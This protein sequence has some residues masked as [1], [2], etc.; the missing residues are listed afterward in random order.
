MEEAVN[1]KCC[2]KLQKSPSERLDTFE[3]VY[4]DSTMGKSNVFKWHKRSREG[5]EDVN[6]NERKI[7]PVTRRMNENVAKIRELVG[8]D[9]QLTCC[10]I[11][12]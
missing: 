4:G 8:F 1:V 10:K 9:R 5:G 2:V 11:A 12:D 6:D 3:T 7:A